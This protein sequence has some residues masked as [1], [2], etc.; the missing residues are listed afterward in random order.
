MKQIQIIYSSRFL[1][2]KPV[3]L[4]D[5]TRKHTKTQQLFL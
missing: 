5:F 2:F 4:K 3:L 1:Y